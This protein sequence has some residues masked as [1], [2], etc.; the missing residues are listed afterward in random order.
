MIL[1][2]LNLFQVVDTS[3]VD[4]VE[5]IF[6]LKVL[7]IYKIYLRFWKNKNKL[8]IKVMTFEFLNYCKK[9]K[10]S[11]LI[12]T[13]HNA[14]QKEFPKF[15]NNL[16]SDLPISGSESDDAWIEGVWDDR[17]DA[18]REGRQVEQ[19]TSAIVVESNYVAI[20]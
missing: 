16:H 10:R 7:T 4:L 12:C 1:A 5:D 8:H 3:N 6:Q 20:L 13:I 19:V 11:C 17:E 18:G 15:I 14:S 9:W 2:E